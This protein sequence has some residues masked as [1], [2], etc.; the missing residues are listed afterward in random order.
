MRVRSRA[1]SFHY[2]RNIDDACILR[3]TVA[4]VNRRL[5]LL[6]RCALP[7]PLWQNKFKKPASNRRRVTTEAQRNTEKMR[8]E[9]KGEFC[10][11]GSRDGQMSV[12]FAG[13]F[14]HFIVSE[15]TSVPLRVLRGKPFS[16]FPSAKASLAPS[17]FRTRFGR[18]GQLV[19][20][21]ILLDTRTSAL[22]AVVVL[23]ELARLANRQSFP[24]FFRSP[25]RHAGESPAGH[26]PGE[27]PA[28]NQ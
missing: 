9:W 13:S 7:C 4:S 11:E 17:A 22:H 3:R 8:W 2:S 23:Q 15:L 28:S 24:D 21:L 26:R 12:V 10:S 5:R 20:Q 25:P 27:V 16:S 19:D 14:L 6:S 18:K 1:W